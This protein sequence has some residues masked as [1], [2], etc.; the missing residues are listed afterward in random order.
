MPLGLVELT[1]RQLH[2]AGRR[3]PQEQAADG[4]PG[5]KR[6]QGRAI[7]REPLIHEHRGREAGLGD[8][9]GGLGR[10][11]VPDDSERGSAAV[12]L[13]HE[14]TQLRDLLSAEDSPEVPDEDEDGRALAPEI[15]E[16]MRMACEIE[17]RERGEAF[18]DVHPLIAPGTAP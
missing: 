7:G 8:E 4:A 18:G 15:T 6:A 14:V 10:R 5:I 16:A 9:I 3:R 13:G 17:D 1:R 12:N 11:P 2:E